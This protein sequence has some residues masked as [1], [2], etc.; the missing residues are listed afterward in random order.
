MPPC[1]R[2]W[3]VA[4]YLIEAGADVTYK[5]KDGMTAFD[6]ALLV[7]IGLNDQELFQLLCQRVA[8]ST[9][10]SLKL[11][12]SPLAPAVALNKENLE[13]TSFWKKLFA[14]PW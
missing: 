10:P 13:S 7:D 4:K 12:S 1:F 5:T 9:T 14:M 3:D 6:V 11:T 8:T 2:K